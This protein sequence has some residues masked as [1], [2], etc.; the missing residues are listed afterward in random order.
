MP[1][2]VVAWKRQWFW[3][4]SDISMTQG[5]AKRISLL[6]SSEPSVHAVW[7]VK[8]GRVNEV[9]MSWI[10]SRSRGGR[11]SC[12]SL[13]M[14]AGSYSAIGSIEVLYHPPGAN[15]STICEPSLGEALPSQR[16]KLLD[17][18]FC[19]PPSNFIASILK[20]RTESR[21]SLNHG[22]VSRR[23]LLDEATTPWTA[24]TPPWCHFGARFCQVE[25]GKRACY[26]T[27]NDVAPHETSVRLTR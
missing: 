10:S 11:G 1:E 23:S 6:R 16:L 24:S 3:C 26:F 9:S 25:V 13:S 4:A 20:Y 15:I 14:F 21:T 27:P 17:R 5:L 19:R 2:C 18:P 7:D 8:A 12:G 22:P